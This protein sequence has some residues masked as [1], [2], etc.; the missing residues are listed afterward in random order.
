MLNFNQSYVT[1]YPSATLTVAF[2]CSLS[3]LLLLGN[4]PGALFAVGY[5]AVSLV[6]FSSSADYRLK[7]GSVVPLAAGKRPLWSN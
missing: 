6:W 3:V 4:W 2:L 1:T 5:S 7:V